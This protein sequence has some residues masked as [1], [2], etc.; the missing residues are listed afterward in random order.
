MVLE[1]GS[2][3]RAEGKQAASLLDISL[4]SASSHWLVISC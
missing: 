4:Q 2:Q 3:L 1:V